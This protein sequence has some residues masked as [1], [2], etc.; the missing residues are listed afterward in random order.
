MPAPNWL[1]A[2]ILHRRP[3]RETSYL[4]DFFTL[5]YGKMSAVAKGV[6]NSRNERKSLL[7]PFQPLRIQLTGKSELKNLT[8]LEGAS[9]AFSLG[10]FN[11]FCAMYLN[12]V[13]N[14]VL[15]PELPVGDLFEAYQNALQALS[16]LSNTPTEEAQ[17]I[18]REFEFALL[19]EMGLLVDLSVTTDSGL[20][21]HSAD[22]YMFDAEM[23][24]TLA[25]LGY[26]HR[27]PGYHLLAIMQRK[28]SADSLRIA[29]Y[30]NRIALRPLLGDKPLKSRELFVVNTS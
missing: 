28:W 8:Q 30:I 19:T 5:E 1:N 21:V 11:L 17:I 27:L 10:G 25:P 7:Q 13:T 16:G 3:Y 6:R 12:E 18:L 2:C 15:Q 14:R 20:P 24:L 23:G 22:F 4:V 9:K 29:K 26:P